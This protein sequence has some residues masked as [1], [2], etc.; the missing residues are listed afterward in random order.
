MNKQLSVFLFLCL[1]FTVNAETESKFYTGLWEYTIDVKMPA[2][3]ESE[4]KRVQKCIKELNEVINLFKPYPSC[5]VSHVQVGASQLSWNLYCKTGG[6]T[7]HGDAKLEGNEHELQGRVDLQ[8]IIPG[9]KNIMR[10]SY[11]ISGKNKGPCQ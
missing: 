8:T 10:T 6:G 9:M 5:S 3:P 7:Y 11:L 2:M 4:L 1:P